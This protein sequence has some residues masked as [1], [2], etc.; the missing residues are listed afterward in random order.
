MHQ[1]SR[2][3]GFADLKCQL[4][5]T[6]CTNL[7]RFATKQAFDGT[8]SLSF[9]SVG[10]RVQLCYERLKVLQVLLCRG[11]GTNEVNLVL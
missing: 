2:S 5:G 9:A 4:L 1:I 8:G 11:F 7:H 3:R 10:Y 6:E